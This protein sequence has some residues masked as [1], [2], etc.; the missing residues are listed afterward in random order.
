LF[1]CFFPSDKIAFFPCFF[2]GANIRMR[3]GE[4]FN[5]TWF[6]ADLNRNV[7]NVRQTKTGKDRVVPMNDKVRLMLEGLPKTNEYV[8]TSPRTNGKLVDVKKGFRKALEDA[9]IFNFHFHDLRHT[10]ATR[11]ADAGVP[12]SVISE[13][14]GHSDIRMTKRYSHATDRAKREAVQKLTEIENDKQVISKTRKKGKRQPIQI[15]L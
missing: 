1:F 10:F 3:R 7:L 9:K 2:S 15:A 12:L 11:L 4:I 8:F 6:D 5:L 14:L 13:L